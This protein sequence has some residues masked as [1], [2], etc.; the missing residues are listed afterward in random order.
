[1]R[2]VDTRGAP[3]LRSVVAGLRTDLD[4]V[5]AGLTLDD[6]CGVVEGI[7]NRIK[8]IKRQMFGRAN[9]TYYASES[10]TQPEHRPMP[11][12]KYVPEPVSVITTGE[13]QA[14]SS[15]DHFGGGHDCVEDLS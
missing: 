8:M 10:S 5:T 11:S 15:V 14:E 3:A 13:D 9:S 6:S 7:V 4:A 2:D 1:M 12:T